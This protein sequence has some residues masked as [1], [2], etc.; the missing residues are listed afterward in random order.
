MAETE[1]PK[2]PMDLGSRNLIKIANLSIIV[3]VLGHLFV[4]EDGKMAQR[5]G[6]DRGRGRGS[7]FSNGQFTCM[8]G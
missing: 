3:V 4:A 6:R 1:N 7:I 8:S 2:E 5:G